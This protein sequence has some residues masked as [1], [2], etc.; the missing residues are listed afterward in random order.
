[1]ET[2]VLRV[3]EKIT[4]AK[5]S[6]WDESGAVCVEGGGAVTLEVRGEDNGE[7]EASC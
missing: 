1:M 3:K 5:K 6:R 2:T 4:I 7:K